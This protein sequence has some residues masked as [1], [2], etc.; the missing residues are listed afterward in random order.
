M[1]IVK[2]W[3]VERIIDFLFFFFFSVF[4][5]HD[6]LKCKL[7]ES[8]PL[9]SF[10][11]CITISSIQIIIYSLL[12]QFVTC[13]C[14]RIFSAVDILIAVNKACKPCAVWNEDFSQILVLQTLLKIK[15]SFCTENSSCYLILN[16]P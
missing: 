7:H 9:D 6:T 12:L 11:I 4:C 3:F 13:H 2:R 10:S 15:N 16:K 14:P 1:Y 5:F 8:Y